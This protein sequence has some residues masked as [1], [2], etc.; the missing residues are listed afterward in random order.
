MIKVKIYK[1]YNELSKK[2][3]SIVIKQIRNKP[4]SVLALPT[5][6][7]PKGMYKNLVNCFQNGKIS[8]KKVAIFNLDEYVGV[9]P[10]DSKSFAFFMQKNFFSKVDV[11]SQKTFIP[12]GLSSDLKKECKE[13]EE[14]IKRYGPIDLCIL[15]IGENGHIGFNEPGTDPK[16]PTHIAKL[17]KE[18]FNK[19]KAPNELA[20]TMGIATILKS[21]KIILLASGREKASAIKKAI[22]GPITKNC[23]A[24]FL[25][26]HKNCTFLIDEKAASMLNLNQ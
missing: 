4:D 23:P 26:L 14:K 10:T 9:S 17:S 24:S 19:N 11:N 3:A 13:Y 8:F 16:L 25:K 15:G 22:C 6:N 5:G 2:I 21:K 18:T 1:N 12:N 7:T 20:I